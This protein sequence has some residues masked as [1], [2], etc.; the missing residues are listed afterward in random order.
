[1]G[2]KSIP[3]EETR[4]V[5]EAI[6]KGAKIPD[7]AAE[8]GLSPNTVQHSWRKWAEQLGYTVPQSLTVKNKDIPDEVKKAI[9]EQIIAGQVVSKVGA[10]YGVSETMVQNRWR[11]WAEQ[12]GIEAPPPRQGKSQRKHR[13][14]KM[15]A[16]E[17]LI[18]KRKRA[19]HLKAQGWRD[20]QV[21][22]DVQLPAREIGLWWKQ[23][24]RM[25]GTA[26]EVE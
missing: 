8:A 26:W 24:A 4:P 5:V 2:R 16:E 23:W 14:G 11:E 7:A 1:M 21:A 22:Q 20:D 12:F 3:A 10:Q 17:R 19:V 18:A 25:Y 15:T 13:F 9:V 6:L